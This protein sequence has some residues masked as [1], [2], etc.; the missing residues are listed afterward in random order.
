MVF[1]EMLSYFE[2]F[3]FYEFTGVLHCESKCRKHVLPMYHLWLSICKLRKIEP[4]SIIY[5]KP[6]HFHTVLT[7][8]KASL[9][10]MTYLN[11][12]LSKIN[13]FLHKC[14]VWVLYLLCR[15]QMLADALLLSIWQEHELIRLYSTTIERFIFK[16][17]P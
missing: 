3:F 13:H 17:F 5:L 15:S 16:P 10:L 11:Q 9:H 2:F 7:E 4:Y 8:I 6:A 1:Q 12:K 14:S